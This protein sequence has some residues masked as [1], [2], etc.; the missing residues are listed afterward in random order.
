MPLQDTPLSLPLQRRYIT[1]YM[2]LACSNSTAYK[3]PIVT[4][5]SLVAAVSCHGDIGLWHGILTVRN[6]VGVDCVW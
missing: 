3:S 1:L 6:L 5:E 2:Q 4:G